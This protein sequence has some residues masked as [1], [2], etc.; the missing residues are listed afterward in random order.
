MKAFAH[1]IA[2]SNDG[3]WRAWF[4]HDPESVCQGEDWAQAVAV[5][6]DTHGS[7]R[8]KWDHIITVDETSRIDHAEFLVPYFSPKRQLFTGS[9]N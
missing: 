3:S 6:I 1:V 4:R 2:E 8:L 7:P 9:L 5:L